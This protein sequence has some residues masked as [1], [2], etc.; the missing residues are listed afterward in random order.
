M[1][2]SG[3][4]SAILGFYFCRRSLQGKP[5]WRRLA[6]S[7]GK[8]NLVECGEGLKRASYMMTGETL[9]DF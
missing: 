6:V 3:F 8:E 4:I 9:G 7:T 1:V 5:A 2:L